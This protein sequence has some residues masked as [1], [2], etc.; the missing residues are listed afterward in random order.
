MLPF[1]YVARQA[2]VEIEIQGAPVL[3]KLG[4]RDRTQAV[5]LA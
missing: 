1:G 3:A 2:D 5:V 4:C